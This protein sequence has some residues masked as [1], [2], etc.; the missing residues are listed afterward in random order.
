[1]THIFIT[2][3]DF[4]NT[5]KTFEYLLWFQPSLWAIIL[6]DNYIQ[7]NLPKITLNTH[8]NYFWKNRI[9]KNENEKKDIKKA[10]E[11]INNVYLHI[12]KLA[13]SHKLNWK[14]EKEVRSIIVSKIL[15]LWWTSESFDSIVAFW[16]NSSIPHHEASDTI[17]STWP[18]LIDMWALYNGYCSDFTRTFWIWEKTENISH[19]NYISEGQEVAKYD[20]F[21]KIYEIVRLSHLESIKNFKPWM[22]WKDLDKISRDYIEK[23]WYWDYY[24]HSL[25][26]GVWLD[27]HEEPKISKSWN[28]ELENWMVFTIEPWIYLPWK[29]WVRLEDIVF[30]SNNNLE[31]HTKIDL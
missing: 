17:I 25:W 1:M 29:F 11:I 13:D 12:K 19:S 23:S 16:E 5:D 26:H 18:L 8:E 4:S 31:K 24:T 6:D 28:E 21:K 15:E 3:T 22:T 2:D 27:I 20:E 9:L 14:T 30:L 10:I 7:E